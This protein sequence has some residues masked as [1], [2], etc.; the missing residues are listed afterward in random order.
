MA[1]RMVDARER[2]VPVAPARAFA[3][4]RRIGGTTGWY[5]GNRLWRLRGFLDLLAGG[6]GL[7]R[8]RLNA[9]MPMIGSALDFWRVDAYEPDRLL[10]LR[11]EMRLPGRAWL[12]FEVEGVDGRSRIRQT[13]VFAPSGLAGFLYW[14]GLLPLHVL[15]FRG[16]LD[17]I[18]REAAREGN[19]D[20]TV[21]PRKRLA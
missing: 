7:R 8:G 5:Y 12:Q 14:Y 15:V 21:S 13:A 19:A 3:P 18:A 6:V 2:D 16:M 11:A 9:E 1:G 4:I 17:G 20:A 10:R